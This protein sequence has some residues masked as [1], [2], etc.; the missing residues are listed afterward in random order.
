[1]TDLEFD[2]MDELYFVIS[3]EEL[4]S[5]LDLQEDILRDQLEGLIR[6]GWVKC[7][8]KG[9]DEEFD[10]VENFYFNYKKYN[11]LATKAGL[12]MHNRK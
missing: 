1:M 7:L 2:I 4:Q 11:F 5:T 3:F 6:K 12:L 9:S 10:Q 8:K